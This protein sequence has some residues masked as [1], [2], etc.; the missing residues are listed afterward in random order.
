MVPNHG[1]SPDLRLECISTVGI[2]A[3]QILVVRELDRERHFHRMAISIGKSGP[4][5]IHRNPVFPSSCESSQ[6][7]KGRRNLTLRNWR[8]RINWQRWNT[9]WTE[10]T[11]LVSRHAFTALCHSKCHGKSAISCR[12]PRL[13]TWPLSGC[14]CEGSLSWYNTIT[15]RSVGLHTLYALILNGYAWYNLWG[16][17]MRRQPPFSSTHHESC[18]NI[19]EESPN[20]VNTQSTT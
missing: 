5:A 19:F 14:S 2:Q 10:T 18:L 13:K 16:A 4:N 6:T 11:A 17:G 7:I 1:S 12:L 9:P 3:L 20:S 8:I 15:P